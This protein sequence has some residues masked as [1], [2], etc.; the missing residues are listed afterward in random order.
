MKKVFY[1]I[2][3]AVAALILI[4]VLFAAPLYA[5]DMREGEW[6]TVTEMVM[7]GMPFSMPPTK[8][9][10]CITKQD[11]VPTKGKE[12]K[13]CTIKEQKVTGNTVRWSIVCKDK[14]STSEG[15]GE[16]TYSGRSYRGSIQMTD[17]KKGGAPDRITMKM[18]GKHL[19]PC[20]KETIAAEKERE[21]QMREAE[22]G[23]KKG[24]KE[25]E[26]IMA[27]QKK[28]EEQRKKDEEES[29]RRAEIII[30]KVRVPDEGSDACI[31]YE[32]SPDEDSP[33][34][35]KE[36][37]SKM[38]ELNLK[39]GKW[40][41]F[42]EKAAR[43]HSQLKDLNIQRFSTD[44]ATSETVCLTRAWPLAGLKK[45]GSNCGSQEIVVK[46]SG[47]KLTWKYQC[48]SA[49]GGQ[50][51]TTEGKGG[52]TFSGDNYE[53]GIIVKTSTKGLGSTS[54]NTE[55]TSLSGRLIDAAG[56]C[57]GLD[58]TTTVER[59]HTSGKETKKDA[60]EEAIQ[61]PV[62]SIKKLFGW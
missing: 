17:T 47:N 24:M 9:T 54:T 13:N 18:S 49:Y 14:D 12:D 38:G 60:A 32:D 39:T 62:K 36:C 4:T 45:G 5:V 43:D 29:R 26:N 6:E 42:S 33:K 41:I 21:K 30:A 58:F 15:K 53:G 16:I 35:S 37:D 57:V 52:V 10:Q 31:F 27:Q 56:R 3:S 8:M 44:K 61:N 11:L 23:A 2:H 19:G 25:V 50:S 46:R 40:E 1:C 59:S 28:D 22:A 55:Y 34:K 48:S 7:E 51:T 20:T